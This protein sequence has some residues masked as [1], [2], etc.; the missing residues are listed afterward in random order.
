MAVVVRSLAMTYYAGH[1]LEAHSHPWG[2]L[3]YAASGVMRVTLQNT[4]WVVPPTRAI[5]APPDVHHE[6]D[7]RGDYS[8]RTIYI[9]PEFSDR[10]PTAGGALQVTPLLRELVLRI[11]A[12]GMLDDAQ[13][14]A[15]IHVLLDELT[16]AQTS[17]MSLTFPRDRRARVVAERL[18][19][20]PTT[21]LDL[22]TIAADAG[23]SARTI[24]RLFR[25]E[26]G[27]RFTQWRRR[28]RVLNALQLLNDGVSVTVAGVE[29][30]YASTSAFVAAFREEMGFTPAK[31]HARPGAPAMP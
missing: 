15:L 22:A 8:M 30:G 4:F 29:A 16:Q 6:I 28:L 17:Q 20:D 10:L 12:I 1:H 24:Q 27:L 9:A 19:Q 23:A 21:G 5:W 2:Q 26:T 3:V 11:V 14:A 31:C 25:D 13:H 18:S 7:A